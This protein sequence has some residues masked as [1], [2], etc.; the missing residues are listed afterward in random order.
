[1]A[2]V[3]GAELVG[4]YAVRIRWQDGHDAGIY[5]YATLRRLGSAEQR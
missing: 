2:T 4:H 3:A 1:M 5:D